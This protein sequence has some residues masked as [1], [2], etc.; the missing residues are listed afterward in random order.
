[1][2]PVAVPSDD[3]SP[4]FYTDARAPIRQRMKKISEPTAY[5][6]GLD[7]VNVLPRDALFH[8]MQ[9]GDQIGIP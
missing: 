6:F 3:S 7:Y 1:M 2:L 9:K 8:A 4:E 5:R